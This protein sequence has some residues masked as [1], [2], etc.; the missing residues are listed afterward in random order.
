MEKI[1]IPNSVTS[2][3][4]S[5]FYGCTSL[6]K[7]TM[8]N[9]VKSIEDYT[10]YECTNLKNVLFSKNLTSINEYA[11]NCEALLLAGNNATANYDV[12]YYKGKFNAYQRTYVLT[13][14]DKGIYEY[15][16]Y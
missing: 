3:G 15:F 5:A 6:T 2:I 7:I 1:T 9:S 8:P 10:F 11:F 12:K 13:L 16:K 4:Q 14:K